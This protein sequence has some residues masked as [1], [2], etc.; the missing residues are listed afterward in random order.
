VFE[1]LKKFMNVKE[2]IHYFEAAEPKLTKTGFMVVGKHNL[3]LVMMK[4]GLFGCTEAEVVE[5]KDIKEVDFD[6]I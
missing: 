5:Y 6:F 1:A 2:K 4:G 3:Y